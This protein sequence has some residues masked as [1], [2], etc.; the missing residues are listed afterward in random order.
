MKLEFTRDDIESRRKAD[1]GHCGDQTM[2]LNDRIEEAR[3][4]FLANWKNGMRHADFKRIVN[5]VF[6]LLKEPAA[7]QWE[8]GST[9]A[10]LTD[11][12]P[13]GRCGGCYGKPIGT[14]I[15]LAK[16]YR[17]YDDVWEDADS[18]FYCPQCA[19]VVAPPSVQDSSNPPEPEMMICEK[20]K[21]QQPQGGPH[22]SCCAEND[23]YAH[24]RFILSKFQPVDFVALCERESWHM[25][26]CIRA[27]QKTGVACFDACMIYAQ[28][29]ADRQSK[30]N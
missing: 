13:S 24:A 18:L 1:S 29:A 5:G 15:K 23:W 16:K 30:E 8:A 21:V 9:V 11:S 25:L 22:D 28:L 17:A 7:L 10:T 12:C 26:R 19:K 14:K 20:D 6:D 2:K 27:M 3:Y 4:Y